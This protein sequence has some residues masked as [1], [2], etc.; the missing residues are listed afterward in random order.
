[1]TRFALPALAVTVLL[2]LALPPFVGLS[3]QNALTKM[4]IASLFAA[5]FNLLAGQA[6][7]LSFGH[8]AYF[9]IGA[10]ATLQLMRAIE[11]GTVAFPTPLLPLAGLAAGLVVG[12]VAGYFSTKRAG[13][14]FSLVTLAIAELL[15]SLAPHW[16]G[17]SHGIP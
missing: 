9:G 14:Y 11:D 15:H 4:L 1:M 3:I 16:E 8:A 2:L 7:L 5:A 12:V 17:R 10:I 6:G 13:V